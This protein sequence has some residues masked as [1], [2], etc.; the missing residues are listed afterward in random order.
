MITFLTIVN[1][2]KSLLRLEIVSFTAIA[3][4]HISL[5]ICYNRGLISIKCTVKWLF[6][7]RLIIALLHLQTVSHRH[8]FAQ[9]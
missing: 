7:P 6:L 5:L 3:C 2:V 9:T 4:L 8:E 1:F